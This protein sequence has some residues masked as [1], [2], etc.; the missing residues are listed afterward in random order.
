[1]RK[2]F[3]MFHRQTNG[4]RKRERE[5]ERERKNM[6]VKGIV[7]RAKSYTKDPR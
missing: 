5:R 1:M 4:K 7:T 2:V 3:L 6:I